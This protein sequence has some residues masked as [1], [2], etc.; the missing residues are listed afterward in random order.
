[1]ILISVIS[2][3]VTTNG[4]TVF[5]QA[6]PVHTATGRNESPTERRLREEMKRERTLVSGSTKKSRATTRG[7]RQFREEL[8][9]PDLGPQ[10]VTIESNV[11]GTSGTGSDSQS[12]DNALVDP[13]AQQSSV[14]KLGSLES[15]ERL[16]IE[17]NPTLNAAFARILA[18]RHEALQASLH[19][20]PQLGL[21]I[22]E[23]GN[24]NDPGIW[25]AYLQ[26]YIVR[27]NKLAIGRKVKNRE[28]GVLEVDLETQIM[29]IQ[30]DV[31][32]A[33]YKL[34]IAQ[35]KHQLAGKLYEAQQDAVAKSSQLF[36]SGETPKTDLLQTQLQAQKTLILLNET[37]ILKK[38]AWRRL[39][40]VI[41]E[42]SLPVRP[43]A[44]SFEPLEETV[45]FE[46]C[47]EQIL[48]NSPEL[49]AAKAEVERV[50]T[51]IDQEIAKSIPNYQT[52]VSV[53]RDSNSNHFFTGLQLQVPLQVYDRNQGNIAAAKSRLV[54]AQNNVD[55]IRLGLSQR[56]ATEYQLY[57]TAVVKSDLYV[58]KLLPNAQQT[59]DLLASGYPEEVSFLRLLTAQQIVIDITI[60]YL[61]AMDQRWSSRLKIEGLLLDNSL[62]Q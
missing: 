29:R 14:S 57:Q 35:E 22:D 16:A 30:T 12:R 13:K 48:V 37:E 50:R 45:S 52:Q 43:V 21:F 3:V 15:F 36:E 42:P 28:A 62:S 19:P 56:L 47:L 58:S 25:G 33:F 9:K 5:A 44:G 1:M 53:G 18:A 20:N 24:D 39:A 31:R 60:D 2:L 26:R 41:G 11:G 4:S 54:V 49:S 10:Q 38:N 17:N 7:E 32:T 51:T 40:A 8:V 34:L 55:K 46:Y 61:D 23:L 59:L 27:G 6:H